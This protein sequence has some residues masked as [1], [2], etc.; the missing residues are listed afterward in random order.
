MLVGI[1]ER[2]RECASTCLG[3]TGTC[4]LGSSL[5]G[6]RKGLACFHVVPECSIA[7]PLRMWVLLA[8]AYLVLP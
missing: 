6:T 4:H 2:E 5:A 1:C 7:E 3:G 8:F